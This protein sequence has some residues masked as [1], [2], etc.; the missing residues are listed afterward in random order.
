[1]GNAVRTL[2]IPIGTVLTSPTYQAMET[3]KLARFNSPVQIN[4]LGDGGQ[5]MQGASD[6]QGV[7]LRSKVTEVPGLETQSW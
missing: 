5:S 1:M 2:N 7:W 4:E 6:G 3:V